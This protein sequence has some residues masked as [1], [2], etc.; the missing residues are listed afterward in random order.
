MR[1][2]PG[3]GCRH[4]KSTNSGDRDFCLRVNAEAWADQCQKQ[5]AAT[6]GG[7]TWAQTQSYIGLYI[8]A[9]VDADGESPIV[10]NVDMKGY[11]KWLNQNYRLALEL[12]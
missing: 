8:P 4:D 5:K 3:S 2:G 12:Q 7:M 9:T 10:G 11:A 6:P 1:L